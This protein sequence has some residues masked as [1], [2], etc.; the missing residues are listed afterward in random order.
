MKDSVGRVEEAVEISTRDIGDEWGGVKG[1]RDGLTREG[2]RSDPSEYVAGNAASE[3]C[4]LN[5]YISSN[6]SFSRSLVAA[7]SER[8]VSSDCRSLRNEK[9]G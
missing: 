7:I 5:A 3:I 2:G 9:K 1:M 8:S 6:S 4:L